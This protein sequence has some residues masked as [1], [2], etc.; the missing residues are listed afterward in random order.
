MSASKGPEIEQ[1]Y[2]FILKNRKDLSPAQAYAEAVSL[3]RSGIAG[4]KLD[5]DIQ[6]KAEQEFAKDPL[7]PGLAQRVN[8]AKLGKNKAEIKAAVDAYQA[9]RKDFYKAKNL[10]LPEGS[11]DTAADSTAGFSLKSERPTS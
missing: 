4:A 6:H 1:I 10:P 8:Q 3:S 5:A 2:N 9:H 11:G 7:T